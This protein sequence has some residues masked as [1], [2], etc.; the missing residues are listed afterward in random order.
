M[1][2]IVAGFVTEPPP[3]ATVY[4][5]QLAGASLEQL[6][7]AADRDWWPNSQ[8]E[9]EWMLLRNWAIQTE[10]L[11][12]DEA[13]DIAWEAAMR[14]LNGRELPYDEWVTERLNALGERLRARKLA[15]ARTRDRYGYKRPRRWKLIARDVRRHY[16][17]W[18]GDEPSS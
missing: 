15:Q 6:L 3:G 10:S 17:E 1:I 9:V 11:M 5:H 16:R 4:T 18:S 14:D 13:E 8:C 12:L 7:E 2:S